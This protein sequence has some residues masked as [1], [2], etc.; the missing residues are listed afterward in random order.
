MKIVPEYSLRKSKKI[1]LH[2]YREY[3][4]REKS[5]ESNRKKTFLDT[6]M[7]LQESI[8][9]KNRKTA[10]ELAR[11]AEALHTSFPKKRF[12]KRLVN[13]LITLS[14]A[15][16]V[17][18]IV[19][20][21][22]FEFY[23]IPTGSM[24]PTFKE[25]D[26]VIVSK[27]KFG[28]NIPLLTKHL[29]FD[30][31]LCKRMSIVIFTVENMKTTDSDMLYFYLFPGKKQF[32]KR[33]VGKPGDILYFYGGRLYGIDKDGHDISKELQN[34]QVT[35][36]EYIPFIRFE[37]KA[38]SGHHS[39]ST[40]RINQMGEDIIKFSEMLPFRFRGEFLH[41]EL[42]EDPS[43]FQEY[44]D[45]WGYKNFAMARLVYPSYV[46]EKEKNYL[47]D[48][49]HYPLL[50]EL[51]HTPT[52][53]NAKI[54]KS[55]TGNLF[56]LI[57]KSV[58]YIP[59]TK[60]HLKKLFQNLYTARFV[61]KNGELIRYGSPNTQSNIH[62]KNLSDGTYEFYN[63]KAY[64][65][66]PTGISIELAQNHP[67]YEFSVEQIYTFFNF[68]IEFNSLLLPNNKDDILLPSRYAYLRDGDLYLLGNPILTKDDPVL[69][70][71][72][73]LEKKKG[74]ALSNYHPFIDHGSPLDSKGG[75][76]TDTIK[77]FGLK[78]PDNHYL[79][80]GDNHAM[81][82]DSRDFGFVPEE[83]I[84][85]TPTIIFWP[86]GNRWGAPIQTIIPWA[87]LP[88]LVIWTLG[89]IS[90]SIGTYISKKKN[91]FPIQFE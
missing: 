17:A 44:Y 36:S 25:N 45:L 43:N 38:L 63:G 46:D 28:I 79:V 86:L 47:G 81:S 51:H 21:M 14:V 83:N 20:Q 68:G 58:A 50:L 56:P 77:R 39:P 1:L 2:L 3:K 31:D 69:I 26:R 89:I 32:I 67:I 23:E 57:S 7:N 8:L 18:V 71:Y 84:K 59:L 37:G 66:Y 15:L 41:S 34:D 78:V 13:F 40:L 30:R 82:A 33:L 19:R 9:Q 61:V 64:Q 87:T 76:N 88:N 70:N 48:L 5:I 85:G 73:N 72:Y 16:V 54:V 80:L 4:A 90:L 10:C 35:V 75:L 65:I 91:R 60:S 24:R 29:Y 27:S 12:L 6:L 55:K 62:I 74:I 22:W 11:K 49:S 53:N 42:Y 52:I